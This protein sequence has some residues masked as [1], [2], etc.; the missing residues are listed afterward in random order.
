[1]TGFKRGDR[2]DGSQGRSVGVGTGG[3][4]DGMARVVRRSGRDAPIATPPALVGE[5]AVVI[6]DAQITVERGFDPQL[7]RDVVLALG[8]PK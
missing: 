1:M 8:F 6:G 4:A 3:R 2:E 7:L 5:I